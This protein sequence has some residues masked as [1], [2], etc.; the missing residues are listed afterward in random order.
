MNSIKQKN[1]RIDTLMRQIK[2][3]NYEIQKQKQCIKKYES[4][5]EKDL[6][7]NNKIEIKVL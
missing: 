4:D 6:K 5:N 2:V 3:L 1:N 7:N